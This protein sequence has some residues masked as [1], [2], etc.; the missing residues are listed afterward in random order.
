MDPLVAAHGVLSA[1]FRLLHG[2]P[3]I[4]EFGAALGFSSPRTAHLWLRRLHSAGKAY[5]AGG[6]YYP[7]FK[8]WR[9]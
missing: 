9:Q 2:P 4:R 6:H 5:Q 8:A 3:T 7:C 1:Q